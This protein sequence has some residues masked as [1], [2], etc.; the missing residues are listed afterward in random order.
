MQNTEREI[1]I[2][3]ILDTA[4][5]LF[6]DK[7]FNRTTT[8]EIARKA[9]VS[10]GLIYFYFSSKEEILTRLIEHIFDEGGGEMADGAEP[11]EFIEQLLESFRTALK[12]MTRWKVATSVL[13]QNQNREAV[14][15]IL[16]NKYVQYYS[17]LKDQFALLGSSEPEMDAKELLAIMDGVA[18]HSIF[19]GDVFKPEAV[20]DFTLKRYR[21]QFGP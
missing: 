15:L 20:L 10:K 11:L 17:I 5:V 18:L 7:G 13:F 21:K 4:L 9:R 1:S 16:K 6:A 14:R 8:D 2:K 3:K 19:A 12:D